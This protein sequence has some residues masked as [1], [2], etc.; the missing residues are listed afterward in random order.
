MGHRSVTGVG[1]SLAGV[2][3]SVGQI[4]VFVA[5]T[6]APVSHVVVITASETLLTLIRA[7]IFLRQ[8]ETCPLKVIV[9]AFAIFA[10]SVLVAL[11]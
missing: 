7:A 5:I 3:A 10:G 6:F 11:A 8:Y 9:A 1:G 4:C 2:G